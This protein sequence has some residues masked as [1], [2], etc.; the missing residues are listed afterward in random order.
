MRTEGFG[1]RSRRERGFTMIEL[2]MV[3][4]IIGTLAA[5]ALPVYQDHVARARVAEGL[6]VAS[7]AKATVS[8]NAV[9]AASGLG[10]GFAGLT[11][12]TTNV[13]S[14]SIDDSNG[15]ITVKFTARVE[16][17]KTLVFVPTSGGASLAP[18]VVPP[19]AIIWRCNTSA[20]TLATRLR[21]PECR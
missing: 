11:A 19:K 20:S 16:A 1:K 8:E 14:V 12:A 17:G 6:Q 4:A 2:M 18:G 7:F 5:V 3:V 13:E 10:H 21:P 15:R 9:N